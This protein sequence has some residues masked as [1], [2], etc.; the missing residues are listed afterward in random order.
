[1]SFVLKLVL[2]TSEAK[3]RISY[4]RMKE[5]SMKEEK[6]GSMKR[7]MKEEERVL[8]ITDGRSGNSLASEDTTGSKGARSKD[9]NGNVVRKKV[10][11][12][13]SGPVDAERS[14]RKYMK[15]EKHASCIHSQPCLEYAAVGF[16]RPFLASYLGSTLFSLAKKGPKLV[17]DPLS[18][19]TDTILRDRSSL[20]FGLFIGSFAGIYK[21]VNCYLRWRC[22]GSEDWHAVV[23]GLLASPTMLLNPNSRI[24]TYFFWKLVET[25]FIKL[26]RAGKI[27]NP[28]AAIY[29]TYSA[30]VSLIAYCILFTPKYMRPSYM[31]LADTVCDS[32]L[33]LMNRCLITFLF[34][35]AI[36]GYEDYFANL[37]PK[38]MTNKFKETVFT[39]LLEC[40]EYN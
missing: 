29:L 16:A 3:K 39:W 28:D 18:T 30:S 4:R 22:N 7:A 13:S 14:I 17:N 8:A 15:T 21:A 10:L 20:K 27:T 34:P 40:K 31:K 1:M 38:L 6:G 5:G 2:G 25:I 24:A 9:R 12:D 35:D 23:G 37:E 26:V 32:K 36:E 19:I 11:K 33:H